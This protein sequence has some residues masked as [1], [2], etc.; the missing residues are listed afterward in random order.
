MEPHRQDRSGSCS[1]A[2]APVIM[3]HCVD[4]H[5][6]HVRGLHERLQRTRDCARQILE[7][8]LVAIGVAAVISNDLE[9]QSKRHHDGHGGHVGTSVTSGQ[10]TPI[11]GKDE[12]SMRHKIALI[13]NLDR[14][15]EELAKIRCTCIPF[16]LAYVLYV[17]TTVRV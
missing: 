13:K 5:S 14:V 16:R 7:E 1:R 4:V 15:R 10:A 12:Q 3:Y 2:T 8:V 11:V 9:K 17:C 6:A